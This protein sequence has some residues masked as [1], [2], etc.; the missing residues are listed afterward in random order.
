MIVYLWHGLCSIVLLSKKLEIKLLDIMSFSPRPSSIW[1]H[2]VKVACL[3]PVDERIKEGTSLALTAFIACWMVKEQCWV[4]EEASKTYYT[5][6]ERR[7]LFHGGSQ[8]DFIWVNVLL[9][10]CFYSRRICAILNYCSI[11]SRAYVLQIFLAGSCMF[12]Q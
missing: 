11:F 6:L 5:M 12:I 2:A 10:H 1:A 3:A 8:R 9:L 7:G 4:V